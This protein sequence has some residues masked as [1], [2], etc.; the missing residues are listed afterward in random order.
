MLKKSVLC[1]LNGFIHSNSPNI[2]HL[3]HTLHTLHIHSFIV[4][5]QAL[6][7]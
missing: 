7:F 6:L 3:Y 1:L 4:V 2:I 5:V